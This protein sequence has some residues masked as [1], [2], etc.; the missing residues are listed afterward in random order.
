MTQSKHFKRHV[1][2]RMAIT[3]Q[4]YTAAAA[5]ALAEMQSRGGL[6][7]DPAGPDL[8]APSPRLRIAFAGWLAGRGTSTQAL[9]TA[10]AL[11]EL[12][13][14]VTL[15]D[16]HPMLDLVQIRRAAPDLPFAIKPLPAAHVA[17][18]ADHVAG[19]CDVIVLDAPALTGRH[20]EIAYG[21]VEY[22]DEIV[23]PVPSNEHECRAVLP[24]NVLRRIRPDARICALLWGGRTNSRSTPAAR[25]LLS[26]EGFEVLD[27]VV[28]R[29]T[30][31]SD[32]TGLLTHVQDDSFPAVAEALLHRHNRAA[33]QRLGP[34]AQ[35]RTVAQQR[36]QRRKTS[37]L[38][39]REREAL[40]KRLWSHLA[41]TSP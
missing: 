14:T 40:R 39:K 1:R 32:M 22:A 35:D 31:Y 19:A 36:A 7:I 2:R 11:A 16:C 29:R 21:C 33:S 13:L 8:D 6:S 37:A 26:A 12:G 28:Y 24:I 18:V 4:R 17:R 41:V 10:L 3:G 5:D 23:I 9:Y 30:A 25:A 15:L 34:S 20:A 38:T 27:P